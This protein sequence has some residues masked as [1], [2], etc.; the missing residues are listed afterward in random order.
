[1]AKRATSRGAGKSST[2][3]TA[4]KAATRKAKP[5]SA[6]P[7]AYT[8]FISHSSKERWIAGQISKEIESLGAKTWFDRKDLHGGDEVRR[9]I[10]RGIRASHEAVVLLSANSITSQWV[11]YEVAIADGQGKRI[12]PVL[13]N[14]APDDVLAPLQGIK[15]IDLNDFDSFL[16]ELAKRITNHADRLRKA[17]S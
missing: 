4:K 12:T 17:A 7:S 14:L 15:A 10:R 6:P 11:I 2:G 13:N 1:M 5:T 9:S 16:V 8:V 3:A